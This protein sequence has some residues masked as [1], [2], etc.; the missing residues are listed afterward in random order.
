MDGGWGRWSYQ[1]AADGI[2][3]QQ[4]LLQG[5][6]AQ[7]GLDALLP[8]DYEGHF[9]LAVQPHPCAPHL[10]FLAASIC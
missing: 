9:L 1:P 5:D 7:N 4:E 8:E 6:R 3:R 10:P 2:R